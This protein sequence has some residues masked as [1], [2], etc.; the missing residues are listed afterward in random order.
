[1]KRMPPVFSVAVAL[2]VAG[3]LMLS[4]GCNPP[5]TGTPVTDG[6]ATIPNDRERNPGDGT[7]T[8]VRPELNDLASANVPGT[9]N[10]EPI[11]PAT[12][13]SAVRTSDPLTVDD[14]ATEDAALDDEPPIVEPPQ[15]IPEDFTV[16]EDALLVD[17]TGLERLDAEYNVWTDP[18]QK[19]VVLAG[20]VARREGPLEMF[21]CLKGTKEHESVVAIH[22][23]AFLIHAALLAVGAEQGSPVRFANEEGEAA[24]RP[25]QGDEIEVTILWL[26]AEG[27]RQQARG[28][29]WVRHI[30][31]GEALDVP[32]VFAGSGFW[33]NDRTGEQ[34]YMAEDGD[35]IC[36]SNFTTAML[37]LP[38]ESSQATAN[39]L[40]E[41]FTERIP[42]QGTPLT[43][44]LT[45]RHG[46]RPAPAA[47]GDPLP[48]RED[49]GSPPAEADL[50]PASDDSD[51]PAREDVPAADAPAPSE[52]ERAPE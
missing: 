8:A 26:D 41:G 51:L 6:S 22:A 10:S 31:T 9:G 33:V 52:D 21:A 23:K 25:A 16:A 19:R 30:K 43:V 11:V 28:Q 14:S 40:F 34:F 44:V 42:P 39:L 15:S 35:I 37:D 1:M 12:G 45:P 2:V 48:A 27:Q 50:P 47:F 5:D 29:D 38:V 7:A 49:L 20:T 32:W 46:S 4:V 17:T 18:Q 24:F 36:V 13:G 3:L